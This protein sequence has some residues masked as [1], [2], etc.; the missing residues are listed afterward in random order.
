RETTRI[1]KLTSLVSKTHQPY[2]NKCNYNHN[3]APLL[4]EGDLQHAYIP[5][6]Y[7]IIR[8]YI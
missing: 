2:Q 4:S 8:I 5:C 7:N 3:F 1:G 6:F